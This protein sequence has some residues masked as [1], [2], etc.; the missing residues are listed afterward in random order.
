MV[1][2]NDWLDILQALGEKDMFDYITL[3]V[4]I[5]SPILLILS[6]WISYKSVKASKESTILNK[7][8]YEDQKKEYNLSFV[9]IFKAKFYSREA[10]S[11]L[12]SL[13]N[14]ND[15]DI[16][17]SHVAGES[18]SKAVFD[19]EIEKGEFHFS[20][21]DYLK[22]DYIKIWLYY[23]TLDH[24]SYASEITLRIINEFFIIESQLTKRKG[25][26]ILVPQY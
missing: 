23:T 3:V 2:K 10:E 22:Q 6:I 16:I 24:K 14:K 4:N 1:A 18:P 8:M 15:K 9:P 26:D 7:Q 13:I 17:V 11:I 20:V 5:L 19:G 25:E 12:F 21:Y